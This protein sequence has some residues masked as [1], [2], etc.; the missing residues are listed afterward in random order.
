MLIS[1]DE[2]KSK[3]MALYLSSGRSLTAGPSSWVD[4][5][6]GV[7]KMEIRG[8]LKGAVDRF[9]W[10]EVTVVDEVEA[11]NVDE[12]TYQHHNHHHRVR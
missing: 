2:L 6:G 11:K 12:K 1:G 4:I 8:E 3:S 10:V 7:A 5:M 9:F